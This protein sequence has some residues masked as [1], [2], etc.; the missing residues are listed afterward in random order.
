MSHLSDFKDDIE[1]WAQIYEKAQKDGVFDDEKDAVPSAQTSTNSYFG[2]VQT[3]SSPEIKDADAAYWNAVHT[4][5]DMDNDEV[6]QEMF[7]LNNLPITDNPVPVWTVGK[8]Q[9]S[10]PG[11]NQPVYSDEDFKNLEELKI[12]FY[13]TGSKI[14]E[15]VAKGKDAKPLETKLESIK[16][17]ID[18][19]SDEI[20][21]TYGNK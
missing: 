16:K 5:P 19:L 15:M 9:D 8:D 2:L 12:N 14:A 3:N 10:Q 20:N 17:Q 13:N 4:L 6:L 11:V 7:K 18:N 1:N 21:T